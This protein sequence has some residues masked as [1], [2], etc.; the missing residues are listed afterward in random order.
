MLTYCILRNVESEDKLEITETGFCFLAFI[1]GPIWGISKSLWLY[2]FI[3]AAIL[4][5]FNLIFEDSNVYLL[6]YLSSISSSFFWG[7]FGRDLYIQKLINNKFLPI[8]HLNASSR[9]KAMVKYLS[10]KLR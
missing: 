5:L 10:D 6:L 3:G 8:A 9:E 4:I 7:F 1:F 2:S